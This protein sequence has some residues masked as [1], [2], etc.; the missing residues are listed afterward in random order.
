MTRKSSSDKK[1]GEKGSKNES[2]DYMKLKTLLESK[3]VTS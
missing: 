1:D 2:R 3:I